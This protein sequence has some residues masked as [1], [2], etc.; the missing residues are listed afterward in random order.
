MCSSCLWGMH[1]LRLGAPFGMDMSETQ[2]SH[3]GSTLVHQLDKIGQQHCCADSN[4]SPARRQVVA[5]THS[6]GATRIPRLPVAPSLT[7]HPRLEH[8]SKHGWYE[9]IRFPEMINGQRVR[10]IFNAV[11]SA[12]LL[13]VRTTN[14]DCSSYEALR[15]TK[16]L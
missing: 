5:V 12:P 16:A 3:L 14:V 1:D 11:S 2:L 6:R 4:L 10:S 8:K 13:R 15:P 9:S 7:A